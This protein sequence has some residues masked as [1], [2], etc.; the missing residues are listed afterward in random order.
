MAGA[1]L[2]FEERAEEQGEELAAE[3]CFDVGGVA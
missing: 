1:D 3:D 2:A